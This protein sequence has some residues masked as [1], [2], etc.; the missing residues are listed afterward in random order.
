V[1]WERAEALE[2]DFD[3]LETAP[4]GQAS[5]A[6]LAPAL[7]R[8]GNF[9][10]WQTLFKRW[11]GGSQALPLLKSP[12]YKTVSQLGESERDFR[13]RLQELANEKRDAM[14]ETLRKRYGSRITVLENRLQRA[15]QQIARESEQASQKKMDTL[16]AF[17][18]AVLGAFLGRKRLST[19]SATRVGS[20]VKTAGRMRKEAAD[21]ERAQQMADTTRRELEALQ[22]QFEQEV[23]K[24]ALDFDAQ[25][26]TLEQIEVKPKSTEIHIHFVGLAWAPYYRNGKGR[27]LPA[28]QQA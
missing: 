1:D 12:T 18:S 24:L 25:R 27:L 6:E 16:I 23:A 15:E 10:E 7:S 13:I 3:K 11:I 17:G 9:A 26:E 19:A 20:A 5:F 28:W 22:T 2:L 8:A 21:V 4:A 14:A